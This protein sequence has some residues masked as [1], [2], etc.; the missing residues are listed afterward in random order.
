[1]STFSRLIIQT[2]QHGLSNS[3]VIE[4]LLESIPHL[5]SKALIAGPVVGSAIRGGLAS[6]VSPDQAVYS[7]LVFTLMHSW[8]ASLR[9]KLEGKSLYFNVRYVA[10]AQVP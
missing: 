6:L 10:R 9:H 8:L 7:I 4:G 5:F 1:V 2:Y 3:N